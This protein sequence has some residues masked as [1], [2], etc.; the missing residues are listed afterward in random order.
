MA[1][2]Y[3]R[4]KVNT[5]HVLAKQEYAVNTGLTRFGFAPIEYGY[6]RNSRPIS[7]TRRPSN[8]EVRMLLDRFRRFQRSLKSSKNR[9]NRTRVTKR[10]TSNDFLITP[11]LAALHFY[12]LGISSPKP[13][14]GSFDEEAAARG[15]ELFE[16]QAKCATC[17]VS[18]LFT[19]PG[20]NM[21]TPEEIGVDDFQANRAP[22]KRYRTA[23]LK[24]LWTHTKG[25]FSHDGR[26]ATLGDVVQHYNS[27]FALS[28]S[29]SQVRDLVEYLKSL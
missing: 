21:H 25:G 4:R 27:F 11:K 16:G 23:P 18:P 19:E 7:E 8:I 9:P 29:A 17:H 13:P 22:D 3:I 5:V 24:G 1:R 14:K 26:F 10:L 20:W 15:K 6:P 12:Q 28:L 2:V